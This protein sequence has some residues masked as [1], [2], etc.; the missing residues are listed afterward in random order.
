MENCFIFIFL[1]CV[2]FVDIQECASDPCLNGA[3]CTDLVNGYE[4]T[5]PPGYEGTN[6]E[7]GKMLIMNFRKCI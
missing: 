6:C 3:T 4:C 7:T 5:C 1:V 2:N